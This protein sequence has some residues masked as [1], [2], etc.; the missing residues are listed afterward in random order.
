[1]PIVLVAVGAWTGVGVADMARYA[2]RLVTLFAVQYEHPGAFAHAPF[3]GA[4]NG[5]VWSLRHEIIVYSLLILAALSGALSKAVPRAVFLAGLLAYVVAGHLVEPYAHSGVL[6][7]LAEGRHVMW[8][9]LLG[10]AAHQFARRVPLHPVIALPGI[11]V[12]VVAEAAGVRVLIEGAIIYLVCAATLLI[13]FPSG[14][15]FKLPHDVSYGVY[16]YSW[17]VQQLTVFFA[18]KAFGIALTPIGL[19]LT[20]MGP[21]LLIALA[22]WLWVERPALA[23]LSSRRP[24]RAA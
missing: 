22:S 3:S 13:A 24:G 6:Y 23:L 9:F 12:L 7:L 15:V 4:L 10:V 11:A 16:I 19:F 21:L 5:S 1:V 14:R 8:S 20:C 18:A 2:L 17:P